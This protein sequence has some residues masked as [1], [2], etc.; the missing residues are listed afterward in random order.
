MFCIQCGNSLPEDAQF[1][2]FCGRAIAGSS[3]SSL[4]VSGSL[5]AAAAPATIAVPP[6]EVTPRTP[7]RA[8]AYASF[9]FS[10]FC[11]AISAAAFVFLLAKAT[12]IGDP[13]EF[14][15]GGS[16]TG[17]IFTAI[18]AVTGWKRIE[19]SEP[20]SVPQFKQQ[21]R[22]FQKKLI[23]F[24]V[25]VL[26]VAAGAGVKVG[27]RAAHER[28]LANLMEQIE[29]LGKQSAPFKSRFVEDVSRE[30]STI[31]QYLQR[32]ADLELVLNNYDPAL[33]QMLSLMSQA[34]GE[35]EE[36]EGKDTKWKGVLLTISTMRSILEKDIEYVG[37]VR[38]EVDAAKQINGQ[39]PTDQVRVYRTQIV[40]MQDA[41]LKVANQER[42]IIKSAS[43]KGV[44]LPP[45]LYRQYGL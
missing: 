29:G 8:G 6:I 41:E 23:A 27:G 43:G 42:E 28:R 39:A 2:R 9:G 7:K 30:S 11:F 19:Q 36:T 26:V 25:L 44:K 40:P 4:S 37:L 45:E 10:V 22:S 14:K 32:C 24:I 38:K 34:Q 12:V 35:I 31:P 20:E 1:C 17:L 5:Q 15:V 16:I 13:N 33:R 3:T 18:W 21:H